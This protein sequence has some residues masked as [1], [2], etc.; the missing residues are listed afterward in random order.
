M[1]SVCVRNARAAGE[2]AGPPAPG[3]CSARSFRWRAVGLDRRVGRMRPE[4]FVMRSPWIRR[5]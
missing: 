5:A 4:K 2:A 1:A 3:T